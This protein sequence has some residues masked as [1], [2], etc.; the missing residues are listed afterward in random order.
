MSRPIYETLDH[1]N[2]EVDVMKEYARLKDLTYQKLPKLS[3]FDYV[4]LSCEGEPCCYM[5]E[6]K[7]RECSV[8]SFRNYMLSMKKIEAAKHLEAA[9]FKAYILVRW[10]DATGMARMINYSYEGVGGRNDRNDP[11]DIEPVAYFDI[12]KS[13]AV[14]RQTNASRQNATRQ[15]ELTVCE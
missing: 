3:H 1:I 12:K 11:Q 8:D 15:P 13:F 6:I 14:R 7:I 2:G 4:V 9:G 10:S 5:V